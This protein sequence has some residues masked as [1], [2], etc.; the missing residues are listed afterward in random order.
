MGA[1]VVEREYTSRDNLAG[2]LLRRLARFL[3]NRDGN[4]GPLM[5]LLIVPMVGALGLATEASN[6]YLTNRASQNAADSAVLAAA[7]NQDT[8]V[9]ISGTNS[10]KGYEW[11]ALSVAKN[12][13]FI[14]A[15]LTSGSADTT[16]S[17]VNGQT[18]PDGV[19]LTCYKVTIS[20]KLPIYLT[21][22]TGF[23][24]NTTTSS[25]ARAQQVS[26]SAMAGPKQI[27]APD[28]VLSL[29]TTGTGI[30]TNGAPKVDLSGCN[31]QSNSTGSKN[32]N[33]AANCN[34]NNL[35]A[36]SVSVV[37]TDSGCG[38]VQISGAPAVS[39]PYAAKASSIPKDPCGSYGQESA[40][41]A[42][43]PTG[44]LGAT[45]YPAKTGYYYL[46][47]DVQLAGDVTI[48]SSQVVVI[49]N[50]QLDLNGHQL[51]S[52]SGVGVTFI[53]AGTNT[54]GSGKNAFTPFHNF[55]DNSSGSKGTLNIAAPTVANEPTGG[56]W[57]GMA[58][59]ESPVQVDSTGPL[60]TAL[61]DQKVTNKY[62]SL[63]ITDAGSSPILLITGVT[64]LPNADVT[65]SGA[66][67]QA[68][69]GMTCFVLV[70]NTLTL[71]GNGSIFQHSQ[72]QCNLAGVTQVYS[73]TYRQVLL[74]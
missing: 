18:C 31:L 35:N 36:D 8:T 43:K 30:Q 24:G 25:G 37:G 13:G 23:T 11:A 17:T 10:Y 6:W 49:Y 9:Y 60:A 64:Y 28:C 46:C 7:N 4:I 52:A 70:V 58:I 56:P 47:G 67:D 39:D 57:A 15:G 50:G 42:V 65:V 20:R 5:A 51:L 27:S 19:T 12:Y 59:Y 2:R 38:N 68:T 45:A 32:P 26:A 55:A 62:Y 48:S 40:G 16:I 33:Y 61:T 34:G 21:A 3:R 69:N 53:F 71:N 44:T 73:T 72:S 63:D 41:T 54:V 66:I 74:Q 14:P 22:I 1:T 29:A